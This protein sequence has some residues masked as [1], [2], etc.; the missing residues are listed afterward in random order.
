MVII[1]LS[2]KKLAKEL[3][4]GD[5]VEIAIIGNQQ[6]LYD[7][8]G[9]RNGLKIDNVEELM[10][11]SETKIS[12]CNELML[13]SLSQIMRFSLEDSDMFVTLQ[14]ELE[15]VKMYLFIQK[16]RLRDSFDVV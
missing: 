13:N 10:T 5:H 7:S 6:I 4:Y 1:N 3:D 15:Y 8:T 11:T 12:V 16:K 9:A 14:K 2:M